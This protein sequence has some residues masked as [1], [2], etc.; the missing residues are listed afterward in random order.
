MVQHLSFMGILTTIL[1]F[2][3]GYQIL[4][5]LSPFL[6]RYF[7]SNLEKKMRQNRNYE[8]S[9][10]INKKKKYNDNKKVGEYIDYEEIDE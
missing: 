3:V 5:L 9:N 10:K 2:I 1:F 7:F 8:K 6:L 4:R